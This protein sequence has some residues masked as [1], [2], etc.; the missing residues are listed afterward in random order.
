LICGKLKPCACR[1]KPDHRLETQKIEQLFDFYAA[2][3]AGMRMATALLSSFPKYS[4]SQHHN[5]K[6]RRIFWE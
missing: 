6:T 5:L 2:R 1:G 3:A 4:K